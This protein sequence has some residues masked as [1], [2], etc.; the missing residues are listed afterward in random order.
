[1]FVVLAC[2][3]ETAMDVGWRA[4]HLADLLRKGHCPLSYTWYLVGIIGGGG[5]PSCL[6][7]LPKLGMLQ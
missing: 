5:I 4:C 6:H 7:A 2:V 1:M 3:A